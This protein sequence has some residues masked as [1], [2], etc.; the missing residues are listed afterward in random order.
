MGAKA[1][2]WRRYLAEGSG[3]PAIGALAQAVDVL[4]GRAATRVVR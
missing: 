4:A 3:L 2:A 1:E